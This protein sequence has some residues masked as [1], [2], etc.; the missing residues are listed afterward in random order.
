MFFNV[1]SLFIETIRKDPFP[2]TLIV[3]I[4]LYWSVWEQI[5]SFLYGVS[6]T[7]STMWKCIHH[8]QDGNIHNLDIFRMRTLMSS[9]NRRIS[10]STNMCNG[11]LLSLHI[12]F[13]FPLQCLL[14][15]HNLYSSLPPYLSAVDKIKL[16]YQHQMLL[17]GH[18][19]HY[20]CGIR[21]MISIITVILRILPALKLW[22]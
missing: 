8:W 3:K 17:G 12:V 15:C 6:H 11:G 7:D 21:D 18:D 2:E 1:C 22:Y 19:Q 9:Y 14:V 4:S 20:Y 13:L 5:F 16:E 10:V